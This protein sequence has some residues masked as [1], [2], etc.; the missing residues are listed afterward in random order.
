MIEAPFL[1]I[2]SPISPGLT[3]KMIRLFRSSITQ[4]RELAPVRVSNS[5]I[6]RMQSS[7]RTIS[8]IVRPSSDW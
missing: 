1:P 5:E 8:A 2:A 6:R 4:S 3:T 7:V